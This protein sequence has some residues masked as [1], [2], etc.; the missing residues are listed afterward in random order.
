MELAEAVVAADHVV[1]VPCAAGDAAAVVDRAA[2]L[3]QSV[4]VGEDD[5]PFAAGEVLG[6]LE[7]E[8]AQV[9]DGADAAAAIFRAVGVGGVLDHRE[10]VPPGDVQ[11]GVHVHRQAAE[12]DGDDR[13][14]ARRD[15]CLHR[16]GSRLKV[17]SSMSAKTGVALASTT[18]VAVAKKV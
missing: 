6:R 2:S 8:R 1:L 15:R 11:H 10:V 16:R 14:G 4:V 9:A 12:V 5:A 17:S 18:A 13:P 3:G 7:G